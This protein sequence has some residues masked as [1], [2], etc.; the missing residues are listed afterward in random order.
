MDYYPEESSADIILDVRGKSFV[1]PLST[2]LSH[3]P[4]YFSARFRPDSMLDPGLVRVDEQGRNVYEID[5]DPVLFQYVL[6][7]MQTNKLPE[8]IG[9]WAANKFLWGGVRARRG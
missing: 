1:V 3:D 7:Y 6:E 9:A 8:G 5:R 2:L 4:S